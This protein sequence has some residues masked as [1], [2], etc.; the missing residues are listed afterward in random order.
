MGDGDEYGQR[1]S[2]RVFSE[3]NTEPDTAETGRRYLTVHHVDWCYRPVEWPLEEDVI[4]VEACPASPSGVGQEVALLD[5]ER[6]LQA[7]EASRHQA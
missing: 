6:I 5:A 3:M 1:W 4:Y 7:F 2:Y